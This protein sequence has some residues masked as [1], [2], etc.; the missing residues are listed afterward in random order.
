MG[1]MKEA[2]QLS[3]DKFLKE[4]TKQSCSGSI[5]DYSGA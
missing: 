1:E 3:A 4:N 5:V 2:N